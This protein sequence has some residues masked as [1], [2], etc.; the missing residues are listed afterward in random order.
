MVRRPCRGVPARPRRTRLVRVA[1][2]AMPDELSGGNQVELAE[3]LT[4]LTI[5]REPSEVDVVR[6]T[7][8]RLCSE[9]IFTFTAGRQN[10]TLTVHTGL[11]ISP[12]AQVFASTHTISSSISSADQSSSEPR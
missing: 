9:G 3:V 5:G 6:R 8:H 11:G 10:S 4:W 12:S 1:R 2:V 7:T